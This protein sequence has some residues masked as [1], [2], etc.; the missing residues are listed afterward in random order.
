MR[1]RGTGYEVQSTGY[2][3]DGRFIGGDGWWGMGYRM[4]G[5]LNEWQGNAFVAVASGQSRVE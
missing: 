2:E 3:V 1:Y 4:D 5:W